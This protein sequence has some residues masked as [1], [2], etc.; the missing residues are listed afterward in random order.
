MEVPHKL[1]PAEMSFSCVERLMPPITTVPRRKR[2]HG[3]RQTQYSGRIP[4][5]AGYRRQFACFH[6]DVQEYRSLE[7]FDGV[8][9]RFSTSPINARDGGIDVVIV[10]WDLV[11]RRLSVVWVHELRLGGAICPRPWPLPTVMKRSTGQSFGER[12]VQHEIRS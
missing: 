1:E 9:S 11:D 10:I 2:S 3:S 12:C 4:D 7:G 8:T 5:S 6:Q